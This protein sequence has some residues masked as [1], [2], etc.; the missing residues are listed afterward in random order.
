MP[1]SITIYILFLVAIALG[2]VL[3]RAERK[4]RANHTE[5]VA[6]HD[7]YRGLDFVLREPSSLGV[8]R[9]IDSMPVEEGTIDTHLALGAV[10]RHRGEADKA[11][12]IHQNLIAHA[13]LSESARARAEFELARDYFAAGL[14]GRAEALLVDLVTRDETWK[15]QAEMLL[16]DIYQREREWVKA[17]RVGR[18]LAKRQPE[19]RRRLAHYCCER[20]ETA[21]AEGDLRAVRRALSE[22]IGFDANCARLYML[23]ARLEESAGRPK[24]VKKQLHKALAQDPSLAVSA[25]DLFERTC[26]ALDDK[27]SWQ[28]FLEE[29]LSYD[30]G[31]VLLR[32][33]VA[34]TDDARAAVSIIEQQMH[35]Y[36]SLDGLRLLL[37]QWQNGGDV[38]DRELA[39]LGEYLQDVEVESAAYRCTGCGFSS[40]VRMW[41]CPSCHAWD[42]TQLDSR[43]AAQERA[44]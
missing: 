11:V 35:R 24:A 25:A 41:Q 37:V 36:P 40:N 19:M 1:E 22:G 27:R 39:L 33:L 44:A 29:G 4:R 10:L 43:S 12:R 32:R 16:V 20:A 14:F 15:E 6:M 13:Q 23:G 3:G 7:Y 2:F 42:S 31:A 5:Q 21:L 38:G 34:L 9:F 26:L 30:S 18:G 17:I 8:E 28:R